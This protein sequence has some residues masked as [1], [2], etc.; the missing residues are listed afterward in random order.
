MKVKSFDARKLYFSEKLIDAM[1]HITKY[2]LTV[3]EAP[4]G[5][6]KT[7]AVKEQLKESNTRILWQTVYDEY[8][9]NFWNGF[10]MRFKEL[11]EQNSKKLL[12]LSL[13][14]DSVSREEALK[15][16]E[17]SIG[18]DKTVLVID[19]YHLIDHP[20][21]HQFITFLVRNE[22][23]NLHIVLITRLIR[24]EH[25]EELKLKGFAYHITKDVLELS[26]K[27]IMKYYRECGILLSSQE[28][29]RLYICTEGWI[30]A[31][32]LF[33]L[34]WVKEPS[35]ENDLICDDLPMI[36]I[37]SLV[38]DICNQLPEKIKEFLFCVCHFDHFTLNQAKYMWNEEVSQL[39]DEIIERN[40]FVTYNM[41][42]KSY[43]IHHILKIYL[44]EQVDKKD[45]TYKKKI[46][47]KSASWYQKQGNYFMAICEFYKA[48]DFDGLLTVVEMDRTICMTTENSNL[49]IKFFNEC[50][51]EVKMKHPLSVLMY[52]LYLFTLNDFKMYEAT[53]EEFIN[54]ILENPNLN[55]EV[56]DMLMGEFEIIQ[57]FTKYNSVSG[58]Y[59]HHQ[60]AI[61]LL[62]EPSVC[63]P[64]DGAWTMG[65]PSVL[66]M[67]YKDSGNLEQVGKDMM[68]AM[69]LY[70][71]LTNNHG[72]GAEYAMS[73]ER[74]YNIGDIINAGIDGHKAA[75]MGSKMT[76]TGVYLC[77]V[78]IQI[79]LAMIA[80]D[81]VEVKRLLN[82]LSED[83][84]QKND[85]QFLYMIDMVKGYVYSQL[86]QKDK[87]PFW[88]KN[89][90]IMTSRIFFHAKPYLNIV[91]G[92]V[93]LINGEYLKL[94]GMSDYFVG[95]SSVF[96]NLLGCI[97]NHIY[98]AAAN[99]LIYREEEAL[100]SMNIALDM[101]IPD[102]LYMPFVENCDFIKSILEQILREGNYKKE[103][104]RIINLY[105]KYKIALEKYKGGHFD[106]AKK[107]LTQREVEIARRAAQGLTNKEIGEMLYVSP[108][109]VKT[110]L[111]SIFEKLGV[112]SRS[113]LEQYL[114]E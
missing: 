43:H 18:S 107:K 94:I 34:D 79:R 61:K 63:M 78:F 48:G 110:Q 81:F 14:N 89:G 100:K 19:D 101:A 91:Y 10:C 31:L 84:Q 76:T 20:D 75:N 86:K 24:M 92:R 39:L 72:Y 103:I 87:I 108:N 46:Y 113:Q 38:G 41:R 47:V 45:I 35:I 77:A 68:V 33:M 6:G 104:N 22:I 4:M 97:Y 80:G 82:I 25:F 59:F 70:C 13:P 109:T 57:S 50:P 5:Y 98:M 26:P 2:P 53:C 42:E 21:V 23:T 36:S 27:E 64:T 112:N 30:S 51:L 55:G 74:Y 90:E 52:A 16:V 60:R 17:D 58:M 1:N 73:A 67:F 28:V 105:E 15:I 85:Y 37:Y 111:K 40:M 44:L 99:K 71:K 9:S 29:D 11:N 7:T 54:V 49:F 66:C 65:S 95:I 88:I 114:D 32:Y 12:G 83:E 3:I 8:S 69:P 106:D 62:R 102:S 96:P 56:K 93:L